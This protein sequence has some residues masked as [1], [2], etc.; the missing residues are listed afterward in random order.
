MKSATYTL[1]ISYPCQKGLN[2]F[3]VNSGFACYKRYNAHRESP[4]RFPWNKGSFQ[5]GKPSSKKFAFSLA[6]QAG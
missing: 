4:T 6:V 5:E 3:L 1:S 2:P